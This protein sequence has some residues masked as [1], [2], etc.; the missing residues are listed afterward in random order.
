MQ[1]IKRV[2]VIATILGLAVALSACRRHK[3][4]PLKLGAAD[5]PQ[6][7]VVATIRG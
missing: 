7:E 2:A 5:M 1:G 4:E 3:E 6:A